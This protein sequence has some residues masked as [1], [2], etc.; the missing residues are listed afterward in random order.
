MTTPSL[1]R[2]ESNETSP[3]RRSF[4]RHFSFN[5]SGNLDAST[6]RRERA[7]SGSSVMTPL[8][9]TRYFSRRNEYNL[10]EHSLLLN[11]V[12][13]EKF[14][15]IYSPVAAFWGVVFLTVPAAY[16]YIAMVLLRELCRTFPGTVFHLLQHYAPWLAHTVTAMN[17]VSRWVEIWCCLEAFFYIGLKLHIKWLQTRD[18][19]EASLSAAPMMELPNRLILWDRMMECEA[20]DPVSFLRGWFFEQPV[21]NISKYDVRDFIAWSMF[22][23][24]HQEH[25]TEAEQRQLERF[26]EEVEH[27]FSLHLYGVSLDKCDALDNADTTDFPEEGGI[28]CKEPLKRAC[29]ER[30]G[31]YY[32]ILFYILHLLT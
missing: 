25:L 27:R 5:S 10:K 21:E 19:L 15:G 24:R 29:N 18:P 26:V 20:A 11:P 30:L 22:E 13:G 16:L 14:V 32:T 2:Q 8:L 17:Q 7:G 12:A 1:S 28:F 6:N 4:Q 23:G 31:E 3:L 9:L